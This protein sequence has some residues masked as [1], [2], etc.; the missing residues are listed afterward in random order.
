[1]FT[2]TLAS[3]SIP[4]VY[5][6]SSPVYANETAV[7]AGAGLQDSTAKLCADAECAKPINP[8]GAADAWD[9]S[10]KILMPDVPAF[11]V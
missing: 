3:S 2:I 11:K 6:L 7:V 9:Q 4:S 10:L 8:P 1:M 5:W